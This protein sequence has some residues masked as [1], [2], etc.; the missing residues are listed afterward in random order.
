MDEEGSFGML[1][2]FVTV[3]SKGGPHDDVSY[4][5]GYAMGLLDEKLCQGLGVVEMPV[6]LE[7]VPQADLLAMRYGY[8]MT[9][10]PEGEW[11]MLRL[12]KEEAL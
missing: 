10:T 3:Q 5:A 4:A 9:S 12:V 1:M 7:S 8:R 6:G 11:S 2:P